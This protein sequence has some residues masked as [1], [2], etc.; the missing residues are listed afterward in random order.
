M[1]VSTFIENAAFSKVVTG[2]VIPN[3]DGLVGEFFMGGN[4]DLSIR[5]VAGGPPLVVVGTPIY[6]DGYVYVSGGGYG[7]NRFDTQISPTATSDETIIVILRRHST[8]YPASCYSSSYSGL[9][10]YS[11]KTAYYNGQ[12]GSLSSV[13]DVPPP[14][15]GVSDFHMTAGAGKFSELGEAHIWESGVRT[16]AIAEVAG[17]NRPTAP[18]KFC[19]STGRANYAYF[20]I[21]NRK[22]EVAELDVIYENAKTFMAIRGVTLS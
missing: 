11:G 19:N 15:R 12:S 4:E 9:L 16:T 14:P 6:N 18:Y 5:N 1:S 13:A 2:I 3:R 17:G 20:A 7:D 8:D 21:F 10:N 22:L